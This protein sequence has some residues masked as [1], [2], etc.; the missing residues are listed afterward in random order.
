M[1]HVGDRGM[2]GGSDVIV[3]LGTKITAVHF[4]LEFHFV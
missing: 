2:I 4:E 1:M 3:P